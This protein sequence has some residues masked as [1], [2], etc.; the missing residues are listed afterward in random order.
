MFGSCGDAPIE[1]IVVP[2]LEKTVG[3]QT[4]PVFL[5][6]LTHEDNETPRTQQGL[7]ILAQLTP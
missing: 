3:F 1:V 5:C 4:L 6:Y 2:T 7:Q